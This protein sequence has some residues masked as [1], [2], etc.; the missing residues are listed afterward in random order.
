MWGSWYPDQPIL[1]WQCRAR[2]KG[3]VV[4]AVLLGGPPEIWIDGENGVAG[5]DEVA[6]LRGEY[7]AANLV[8]E[9]RWKRC[10]RRSGR[11]R[12]HRWSSGVVAGQPCAGVRAVI[13]FS[14]LGT[15]KTADRNAR[16]GQRKK[17]CAEKQAIERR[18]CVGGGRETFFYAGGTGAGT[19]RIKYVGRCRWI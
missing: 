8:H 2:R 13:Y 18:A 10:E 11:K 17:N 19:R 1:V 12:I 6:F 15:T 4:E 16:V 9:C 5:R 3:R 7:P 14:K